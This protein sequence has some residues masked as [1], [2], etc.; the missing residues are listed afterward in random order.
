MLEKAKDRGYK[1]LKE[2]FLGAG[3]FPDEYIGKF[4]VAV[5]S[6]VLAHGHVSSELFDEKI[7][8]LSQ[9]AS[10]DDKRYIIFTTREE[11]LE[12]LG[13]GEKLK[14]LENDSKIKFEDKLTFTRY[15]NT[16]N[17]ETGR[18]NPVEVSWFIYTA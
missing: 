16:E 2:V 14:S 17:K 10:D 18:F 15:Q 11:Y 5:S 12:S 1:E 7:S 9:K 13:Y 6:G 8:W 4:D 3:K